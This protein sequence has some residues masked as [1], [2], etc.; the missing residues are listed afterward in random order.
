MIYKDKTIILSILSGLF[1]GILITSTFIR[2]YN[3]SDNHLEK[4]D[5]LSRIISILGYNTYPISNAVHK[6]IASNINKESEKIKEIDKSPLE[7]RKRF[8]NKGYVFIN[9]NLATVNTELNEF[10]ELMRKYDLYILNGCDD[11]DNCQCNFRHK[12]CRLFMIRKYSNSG[13]F[14]FFSPS[15]SKVKVI[16]PSNNDI[17]NG[18]PIHEFTQ[19][20]FNKFSD[21]VMDLVNYVGYI[22]DPNKKSEYV[23]DITMIADPYDK[24]NNQY[25][26]YGICTNSENN[27]DNEKTDISANKTCSVLW[28]QDYFIEATTNQKHAYDFVAMFLLNAHNVT[29]HKI[30]IGKIKSDID[31]KDMSLIN[32]QEHIIPLSDSTIDSNNSSDIGYVIDQRANYYHKHSNFDYIDSNARRNVITIRI[33]NLK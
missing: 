15:C 21:R 16:S 12:R 5:S 26:T 33:K 25:I 27:S 22:I 6:V 30:M 14:Q 32:I 4:N 13:D 31:I 1:T 18:T 24:S 9:Q 17:L 3:K 10:V 8:D 29:P 19:M 11:P 2:Y 20:F 28:H 23:V 7:L